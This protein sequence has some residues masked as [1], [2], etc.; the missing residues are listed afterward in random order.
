MY[1]C[2]G[3]GGSERRMRRKVG[4]DVTKVRKE[5]GEVYVRGREED[6]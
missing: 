1:R 3:S 2:E 4:V 5:G 6:S